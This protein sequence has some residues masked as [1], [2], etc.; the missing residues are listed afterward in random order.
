MQISDSEFI[1]A[2]GLK[3]DYYEFSE[4]VSIILESIENPSEQQI[5]D[6]RESA[7]THRL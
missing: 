2:L 3:I 4:R 6:A 5:D 1:D 7:L